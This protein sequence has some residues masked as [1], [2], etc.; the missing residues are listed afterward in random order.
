M[1]PSPQYDFPI[2]VRKQIWEEEPDVAPLYEGI[3]EVQLNFTISVMFIPAFE[4]RD[5]DWVQQVPENV[6]EI[7]T[8]LEARLITA[9]FSKYSVIPNNARAGTESRFQRLT[10]GISE[11]GIIFY[12]TSEAFAIF[13][14]ELSN[15]AETLPAVHSSRRASEVANLEFVQFLV[16]QIV[17]SNHF[18][19]ADL[20]ILGRG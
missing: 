19:P 13:S 16:S 2:S 4:I 15:F 5:R 11:A 8:E 9:A 6:D 12:V 7:S 18:S 3:F 14:R 17:E 1:K 20:P 10:L